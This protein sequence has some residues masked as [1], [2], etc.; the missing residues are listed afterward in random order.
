MADYVVL[1]H[2]HYDAEFFLTRTVAEYE[3]PADYCFQLRLLEK[4]IVAQGNAQWVVLSC[5]IYSEFQ[6]ED[7]VSVETHYEVCRAFVAHKK[8]EII[9]NERIVQNDLFVSYVA[10]GLGCP[11]TAA[12]EINTIARVWLY[13]ELATRHF[14]YSRGLSHKDIRSGLRVVMQ[15]YVASLPFYKQ[16]WL[17]ASLP[18][19]LL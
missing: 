11:E 4:S 12:D 19:G 18:I 6:L 9:L 14:R 7:W 3:C 13:P 2:I 15:Q 8:Q 10:A 5:Q 16:V 1:S 17:K